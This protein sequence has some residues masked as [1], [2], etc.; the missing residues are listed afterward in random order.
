M[1]LW[2][3][4]ETSSIKLIHGFFTHLREG[5]SKLAALK[6]ARDGIRSEGFDHPFF[7]AGFILVGEAD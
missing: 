3:V 6:L 2:S 7:W 4:A 5:K 1:S